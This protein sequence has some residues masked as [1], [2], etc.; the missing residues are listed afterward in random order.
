M[1]DDLKS[2]SEIDKSDILTKIASFPEQI[3]EAKEII[4]Q[5]PLKKFYKIDDIIISGMGASSISGE[6]IENLLRDRIDIPIFINRRYDLPKWAHKNTLLISQSYSGNTEETLSSFK[7]GFQKRC[8]IIGISSG[9]KLEEFCKNREIPF[10]KIP[11]NYPPRTA[12]GYILF[13]SILALKKIGILKGNYDSEIEE[14]ISITEE[15]KKHSLK[16]IKEEENY[17]KQLANKIFNS[18]PQVYGFNEYAPI[19]K[20]W[21]TQFNENSKLICKYDEVSECNHNDIVGWS[22]NLE[23]SKQFSCIL[24]R[25]HDTESIFMSN[26]LNFMKKL[27]TEVAKNVIEVNV[28][29]KKRLSKMMYA[30]LLGDFVSFYL[31]ILRKVDPTPISA[32]SELKDELSKI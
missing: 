17:A 5:T 15:L 18:I 11:Q 3:K 29:G 28:K 13:S 20:R 27:F 30:M 32:I 22:A 10:I 14:S 19:A 31:A 26:R 6:I 9:G 4:N 2:I 16:E 8:K 24:F 23:T 7:H 25:D 12:T 21:C 1:L